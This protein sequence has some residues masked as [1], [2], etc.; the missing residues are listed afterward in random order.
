MT[1]IEITHIETIRTK[2]PLTVD[3]KRVIK[4]MVIMG[5]NKKE[6]EDFLMKNDCILHITKDM[7]QVEI[8]E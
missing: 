6:I 4:S 5:H 2:S 8:K 7:V 3:E 1:D